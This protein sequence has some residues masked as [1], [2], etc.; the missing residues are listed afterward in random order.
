MSAAKIAI[1]GMACRF[2]GAQ[3]TAEFWQNLCT[4]VESV[5]F[6]SP[7]ELVAAGVEPELVKRPNYI[8]ANAV[9][10]DIDQFDADF[11]GFTPREAEITDPQH[12]LFLT[13]AWQALE[14]AGY[15]PARLE[16]LTGVYAG[17][18]LSSYL[19]YNLAPQR[20]NLPVTNF[21]LV[22]GNNKD[23]VPTRVSYRLNLKGPS[24]NINTACSTSLVAVHLACQGLLDFECDLALAGGVGIQLPQISGYLYEEGGILSPDGHCRPFD[25]QANGTINGSGVGVVVLKRLE[26]ALADGDT[27]DAVI[28]GTAVNNDGADKVGFTAPS[29]TG[30]AQVIAEAQAKAEIH[31]DD[32]SYIETHGTG[33]ALGDPIEIRALTQVFREQTARVGF[34]AIGSV[35]SNI[36]HTDE[37]AGVAGLIKTVLALRHQQLPP[38]LNFSTPNPHLHLEKSP[39]FVNNQLRPWPRTATPRRAGVSSFGIGGTN[40][41][42]ILQEPPMLAPHAPIRP[43]HLLLLSAKTPEALTQAALNLADHLENSP[44]L[45]LA[46]VA[47]TLAVGRQPF[48]YR[49]ALVVAT[50]DEAIAALRQPLPL[51]QPAV[52]AA[53]VGWLLPGQGAQYSQMGRTLYEREPLFRAAVDE[54]AAHFWPH[55]GRDVRQVI[56]SQDDTIHQT[57]YAQPTLFTISYALG[58]LWQAWGIRPHVLLGHSL[59]ELTAVCLSGVLSLADACRLVAVRGRAMQTCPPGQMAAV[60]LGPATLA[61]YLTLHKGVSIAAYNAPERLTVA[62][63]TD[64]MSPFLAQL[65][66]DGVPFTRLTTSHAFH[67]AAMEAAKG[68]LTETAVSIPH[69][70]PQTPTIAN[71]TGTWHTPTPA[72]WGEQLR[73]PVQFAAGL[74]TLLHM[75]IPPTCLLEVGPGHILASLARHNSLELPVFTS[76]PAPKQGADEQQFLLQ[77]VGRLWVHGAVVNWA[78]FYAGQQHSRVHLPTYP[79]QPERYWVEPAVNTSLAIHQPA[80]KQPLSDWFYSPTWQRVPFPPAAPPSPQ[81][82]ALLGELPGAIRRVLQAAGHSFT[83]TADSTATHLLFY[84]P[85]Y[86]ELLKVVQKWHG[87]LTVITQQAFD[88]RGGEPTDPH[89]A[90]LQGLL[91]VIPQERPFVTARHIDIEANTDPTLLLRELAAPAASLVAYRGRSR[92]LQTYQKWPLGTAEPTPLKQSGTYLVTGGWGGIGLITADFLA[93]TAAANIALLGRTPFPARETWPHYFPAHL[94]ANFLA[95]HL[96]TEQEA[97][98]RASLNI[99]PLAAYDGLVEQL[100]DLCNRYLVAFWR[101]CGITFDDGAE[102]ITAVSEKLRLLPQ[103]APFLLFMIQTLAQDG[104]ICQRG[105]EIVPQTAWFTA[106]PAEP[107]ETHLQTQYPQLRGLFN[108]LKHCTSHYAQALSGDMEAITVLY[109]NGRNDLLNTFAAQNT[110]YSQREIYTHLLRHIITHAAQTVDRPLR[111]L[112]FGAGEGI[113]SGLVA[114]AVQGLNVQYTVTDLGRSFVLQLEQR[115]REAGVGIVSSEQYPVNSGLMFRTLDIT[116]NPVGQGFAPHQ[117]D[118]I[119]GL[120]VIHATADLTTSLTHLKTLLAPNGVLALIESVQ[121]QRWIDMIWGLAEGWWYFTDGARR[122]SGPLLD[123]AQWQKV[124]AEEGF[125]AVHSYHQPDSDYGLLLAQTP[126]E[127]AETADSTLPRKIELVYRMEAHG[128]HILPL[129]ADVADT[130]QLTAVFNQLTQTFGKLDG[131]IHAAGDTRAEVIFNSLEETNP[132]QVEAVF[133]ARV[134]GTQNLAEAVAALKQPPDFCL[135]ISSNS[136]VLGGLGLNA[137]ASAAAFMDAFA[138][139]QGWLSA[140]WDSWP[141]EAFLGR[142]LSAQTGIDQFAMT[143]PEA[144]EALARILAHGQGQVIVSAGDLAVRQ[145]KWTFTPDTATQ[146]QSGPPTTT[147]NHTFHSRPVLTSRYETP[148]TPL[149]QTLVTLWQDLLGLAPVGIHD[150]FFELGGDSLLA[151]QVIAGIHRAAGVKLPLS[152]LFDTPTVSALAAMIEGL[153]LEEGEI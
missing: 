51:L 10:D 132:A 41:H 112:E 91:K 110:P 46:D 68:V 123:V 15:D 82:F 121:P 1:I 54:C 49:H 90:M 137:Y 142:E 125:T 40:A 73:Q 106:Q 135:L 128:A 148:Q 4:G 52:T 153:A 152:V 14:D 146:A 97:S 35:K 94:P 61:P 5:R 13:C 59:G 87:P 62:G 32:I 122:T 8:P 37:A 74:Q 67:T 66:A 140:N 18:G 96:F 105:E 84:Q 139:Q 117:Y 31:P 104:Y 136:A 118:F 38:S 23:F 39:F 48:A 28:L 60:S 126:C 7:A 133:R 55:L 27:I 85:T 129:A 99:R 56:L 78:A 116:R 30:Q 150:D 83:T 115:A 42:V 34:C 57:Q 77:T 19:L 44:E 11:F 145:A 65:Q 114:Q 70:P 86:H 151:V 33:T 127:A 2:P 53:A 20:E 103:F 149:Q 16:G 109:P 3:N 26:D 141:T 36:G 50:R 147:T 47:Y 111:L 69:H 102:P 101:Q 131:L 43:F 107:L 6:F 75:V 95:V 138:A 92:W 124:L 119:F 12:R 64:A 134:Q 81:Q 71:T 72:Y 22:L 100:N 76:L 143:L 29:V 25:A 79:F 58:H 93:Q 17:A 63:T 130:A 80:A 24:V 89:Q 113:L 88:V 108:L 98:I 144:Q 120:D 45:A 9:L 21:Q